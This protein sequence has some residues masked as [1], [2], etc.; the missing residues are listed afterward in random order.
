[1]PAA[2]KDKIDHSSRGHALL[3]PSAAHRWMICTP[4]AVFTDKMPDKSSAYAEEGTRAHE[5]AEKRLRDYLAGKK[6]TVKK[7]DESIYSEVFPYI[8]KVTALYEYLKEKSADT[9]M[10]IEQKVTAARWIDQCWGTSDCVIISGSAIYVI[11]L[12]FGK[13]VV[14]D[15]HNNPQARIYGL[16]AYDFFS[17]LYEIDEVHN[18]IIQPR[19]DHYSEEI[20][21]AE[22]LLGWAEKELVPAGKAALIGAGE[23]KPGEHCKF[24]KAAATCRYRAARFNRLHDLSLMDLHLLTNEEVAEAL[25][26]AEELSAWLAALK[27]KVTSELAAGGKMPGWKLVRGRSTR[28]YADVLAVKD[29]LIGAGI[30]EALIY[31]EPELLN[32]T[33]MTKVLGGKK[34]FEELLGDLIVKPEGKPTLVPESDRREA[35]T[36]IV[37]DAFSEPIEGE[38]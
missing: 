4:S 16:G 6:T 11:D 12:K 5:L 17:D 13:G 19:L 21:S 24:C 10:F 2:K 18:I 26:M 8:E 31:K 35:I 34:K 36:D 22:E 7:E 29:K 25:T 32:I 33:D 38:E 27:D 23:F 20:L 9:V 37:T 1:M 15:A 3:S 30:E 28:R 14:V